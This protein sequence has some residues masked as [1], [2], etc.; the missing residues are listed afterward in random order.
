L[1]PWLIESSTVAPAYM[2]VLESDD[3]I[4]VTETFLFKW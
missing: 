1:E 4:R 3:L 2:I